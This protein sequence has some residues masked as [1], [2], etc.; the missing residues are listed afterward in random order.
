[1][2][3]HR[4]LMPPSVEVRAVGAILVSG[5]ITL[6]RGLRVWVPQHILVM[7]TPFPYEG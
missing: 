2:W 7:P 6:Q 3:L 5:H 4:T 1:M